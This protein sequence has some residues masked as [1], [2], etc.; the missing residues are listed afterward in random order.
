MMFNVY[1]F[2]ESTQDDAI[3]ASFASEAEAEAYI[4]ECNA[5]DV[6]EFGEVLTDLWTEEA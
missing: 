6:A 5:D 4:A 1:M 3:V 2:D